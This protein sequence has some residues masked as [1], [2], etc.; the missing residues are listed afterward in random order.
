[1]VRDVILQYLSLYVNVNQ[2]RG[3]TCNPCAHDYFVVFPGSNSKHTELMQCLLPVIVGPSSKTWPKC[4]L[5]RAQTTSVRSRFLQERS[6]WSEIAVP[7]GECIPCELSSTNSTA[8]VS[9]LSN[10]GQPVPESNFVSDTNSE[11]P[12][13][14]HVNTPSRFSSRSFPENGV[15]S[16]SRAKRRTARE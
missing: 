5:Q 4:D 13:A 7:L 11:F 12:H 2:A 8:P 3:I 10:D 1:M 15:P 14:T 16:P 6:D 9:A